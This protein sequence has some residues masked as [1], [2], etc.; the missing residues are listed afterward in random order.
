MNAT[1]ATP[2]LDRL[3]DPVTDCLTTEALRQLVNL[4]ADPVL[5]A[6]LD[7]LAD[8]NTEGQL[9]AEEREEYETYVQAIHLISI[10]QSKARKLLASQT[11]Q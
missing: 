2:V 1:N 8:K 3:F 4:H 7:T 5:Q 10:L 11:V 6:R 9:G